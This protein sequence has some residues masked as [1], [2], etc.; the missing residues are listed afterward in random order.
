M[1]RTRAIAAL[2]GP[3]FLVTG[4][5]LLVDLG[6]WDAVVADLARAPMLLLLAG[7]MTFVPGLAIVYA[8]NR[9]HGGAL[10]VTVTA[11]GWLFVAAGIVRIV[12]AYGLAAAVVPV[13]A[14][15]TT[16]IGWLAIAMLA[17]G[18]W[19]GWEGWVARDA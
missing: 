8:H 18:A 11:I 13:A 4:A 1:G 6:R 3:V 14:G 17:L 9:W 16:L 5:M 19:L 12:G 2:L 10:T 15:L 7:Y